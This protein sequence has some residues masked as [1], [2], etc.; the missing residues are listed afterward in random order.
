MYMYKVPSVREDLDSLTFSVKWP[1]SRYF[2]V[3]RRNLLVNHE[4]DNV[5]FLY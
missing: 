3:F 4:Y 1:M 2:R 5:E